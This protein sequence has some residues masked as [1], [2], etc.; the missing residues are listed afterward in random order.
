MQIAHGC[1][2]QPDTVGKKQKLGRLPPKS[3]QFLITRKRKHERGVIFHF[4]AIPALNTQS[5]EVRAFKLQY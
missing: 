3:E 1:G 2:S 5:S 4:V